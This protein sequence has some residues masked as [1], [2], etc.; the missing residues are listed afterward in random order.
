[1]KLLRVLLKIML[2]EQ[3]KKWIKQELTNT[4]TIKEISTLHKN[5]IIELLKYRIN[6]INNKF[7]KER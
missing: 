7:Y 6:Y 3:Y 1:M 5:L 2:D 4:S